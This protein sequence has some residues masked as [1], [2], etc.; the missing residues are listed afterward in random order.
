MS[1][2]F[3]KLDQFVNKNIPATS[4]P[5]KPLSFGGKNL[6]WIKGFAL[7]ATLLF[8]VTITET[9]RHQAQNESLLALSEVMSWDLAVEESITEIDEV[10][11]YLE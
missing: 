2:E 8:I 9:K 11:E 3:R 1:E 4:A 6:N 10:M 7:T 5:L